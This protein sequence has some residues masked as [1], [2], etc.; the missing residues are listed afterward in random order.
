MGTSVSAPLTAVLPIGRPNGAPAS[1]STL[2]DASGGGTNQKTQAAEGG[3]GAED[4]FAQLASIQG[5]LGESGGGSG[6]GDTTAPTAATEETT[7]EN[8]KGSDGSGGVAAAAPAAAP[9][10]LFAQLAAAQAPA[11][12]ERP[13]LSRPT[14]A[15][16]TEPRPT[17]ESMVPIAV[18]AG[19]L[20]MLVVVV[21]GVGLWFWMSRPKRSTPTDS[22]GP[23][24]VINK[25]K[26]DRATENPV[27]AAASEDQKSGSKQ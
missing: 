5:A 4:L 18:V 10:D 12:I 23:V 7:G 19:G 11:N 24:T 13:T 8:G 14:S 27:Q 6:D 25:P 21:I 17:T 9:A 1:S 16:V 20:T 15:P 26:A 2:Y 3:G 22:V